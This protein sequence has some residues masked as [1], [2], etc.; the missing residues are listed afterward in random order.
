MQY[1]ILFEFI[2]W[3]SGGQKV[4]ICEMLRFNTAF[5]DKNKPPDIEGV[6]CIYNQ[7]ENKSF[8]CGMISTEFK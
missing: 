8:I 1:R 6:K 5:L 7:G 2:N 3:L 4:T